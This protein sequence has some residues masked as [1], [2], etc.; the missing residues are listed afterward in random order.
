MSVLNANSLR[1][2]KANGGACTRAKC[3][4]GMCKNYTCPGNKQRIANT[5]NVIC[6]QVGG[7]FEACAETVCCERKYTFFF[8]VFVFLFC[9]VCISLTL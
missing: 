7:A 2:E 8:V 5:N 4:R 1:C 6:E 9:G 3:C